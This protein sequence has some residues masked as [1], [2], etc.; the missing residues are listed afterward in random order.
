MT[1]IAGLWRFDGRPDAAERCERMLAALRMYGRDDVLAWDG[2]EVAIG[3]ALQRILPE[4]AFDRQPAPGPAG[5]ALVADVRLDNRDELALA[6]DIPG[7]RL[8]RLSDAALIQCAYER[9]DTDAFDR[10]CGAYACALW[11]APRRRLVL[12]RDPLAMRPLCYHRA[13]DFFAFATMPK[14]LH[15]LPDVPYAA[16]DEK[17]AEFLALIPDWGAGTFFRG[18]EKIEAGTFATVDAQGLRVSRH[19]SPPRHTIKLGSPD[20]Y[21][22]SLRERLDAAVAASLRGVTDVAAQLSGGYDST[23]V[24]AT[25]ARLL[26]PAG[27]RVHAFTAAPREGYP[28]DPETGRINDEGPLAAAVAA[29]YPNIEHTLIRA[30]G[31]S[32]LANLDRNFLLYERPLLNLCNNVWGDAIK[33]AVRARRLG[34]MLVG[35]MGNMTFSYTGAE[36][37]PELLRAGRLVAWTR[38]ALAMRRRGARW[39]G[40]AAT[41]FGPWAPPA[42]WRL[43]NRLNGSSERRLDDY[44]MLKTGQP[45]ETRLSERA[46]ERGLDLSYR[47]WANGRAMRLW[48]MRRGDRGA[49]QKGA[50]AGWGIDVRDPTSDRRLVEFCLAVPTDQ[51][52]RDGQPRALARR[53][54]ADRLPAAVLEASGKGY[55]AA[56]WHEGLGADRAGLAE[57]IERMEASGVASGLIATERMR[58][59][60]ED[61]PQSGWERH[62]VTEPYRLAMLRG[63]SAGHFLRRAAGANT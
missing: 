33:D 42:L 49:A 48:V 22:E 11:D 3:R 31:R 10:L 24:T 20:A 38:A 8:R 18:V 62:A 52:L 36:L 45:W 15:A 2:G 32:P 46:R 7:E 63:V 35:S 17:V 14:G 23:A 9:W 59:L 13:A 40:V 29:L 43:A 1:A 53:A 16:D 5:V 30:G 44:A 4:D 28:N 21:A 58:R 6:L 39:R 19:W 60:M 26:A 54:L 57:E 37:M 34:V 51:F 12:A 27:G 25:A 47:P 50:L 55:Q 56:D 61:W 41:S